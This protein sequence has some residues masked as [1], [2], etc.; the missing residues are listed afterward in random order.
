MGF[1]S[2][3][4]LGKK[5]CPNV[6]QMFLH[7]LSQGLYNIC[8]CL[9][10]WDGY[11]IFQW[12]SAFLMVTLKNETGILRHGHL[13]WSKSYLL[14]LCIWWLLITCFQ[15]SSDWLLKIFPNVSSCKTIPYKHTSEQSHVV[16]W[17]QLCFFVW[18]G[19]FFIVS[20]VLKMS[21]KNARKKQMNYIHMNNNKLPQKAELFDH[22]M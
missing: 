15:L 12:E 14:F 19:S 4:T 1:A 11:N 8:T 17:K 9:G 21:S 13:M 20:L 5:A 16:C 2:Y 6:F 18:K 7:D 10:G 22:N 3:W